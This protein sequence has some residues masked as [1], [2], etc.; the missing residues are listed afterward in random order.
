[1]G[2]LFAH[3]LNAYKRWKRAADRVDRPTRSR[4]LSPAALEHRVMQISRMFPDN[5]I[6]GVMP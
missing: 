6:R 5:V 2:V 3:D 1:M 4:S